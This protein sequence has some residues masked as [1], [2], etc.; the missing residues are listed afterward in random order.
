MIQQFKTF[1]KEKKLFAPADKI[2]LAVSGGLDSVVMAH[3]FN[4]AGF[5]FGI[6]HCNFKL[7][8]DESDGDEKFV[9][10]LAENYKVKLFVKNFETEAYATEKSVSIQVAARD[11][12]YSFFESVCAEHD[13]KYVATAHHA[14]DFTETVLM[15]LVRGSSLAALHGIK[16]KNK[17]IIRPLLFATRDEIENYAKERRLIWRED[18]S[19]QKDDYIRN[20]IRHHVIPLLKEINPSLTETFLSNASHIEE[21]EKVLQ[22]YIDAAK[23]AI[24][25]EREEHLEFDIKKLIQLSAPVTF[26]F[27]LLNPYGF[28][29]SVCKDIFHSIQGTETKMFYNDSWCAVK[30]REKLIV[31]KNIQLAKESF[32]ING[33]GHHHFGKLHLNIESVYDA[34]QVKQDVFN[35]KHKD[36]S[37]AFL[38]ADKISFPFTLRHWKEGDSFSPLGIKGK[39]LL[40]DYFIDEKF[41][42]AEKQQQFLLLTENT[43]LWVV[44]KRL[45]E[46]AKLTMETKNILQIKVSYNE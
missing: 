3:L 43:V 7:R 34:D 25:N 37:S 15:N 16:A 6:A 31:R 22:D 13:F 45:A 23:D 40:S 33:A 2:L 32:V 21:T 5:E 44:G 12:R 26:L 36:N 30:E 29:S 17:S 35:N 28:N 24:V 11:L 41:S 19:N 14:D 8:G 4:D 38:D 18:S 39:K 46:Y 42:V 9:K 1:N 20:K 10:E 27:K